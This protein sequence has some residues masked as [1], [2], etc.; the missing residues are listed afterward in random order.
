MKKGESAVGF[1]NRKT[2]GKQRLTDWRR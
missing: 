2:K 1:L